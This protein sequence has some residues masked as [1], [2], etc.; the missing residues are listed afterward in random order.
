MSRPAAVHPA[1]P[2]VSQGITGLLCAE[3]LAFRTWPPVVVALVLILLALAGPRWSPVAWGFRLIARPPD[4]LEPAAPVRF[5]QGIAAVL[6]TAA[7]ALWIAGL[8]TAGWALVGLVAAVALFSAVSGVC[9]GCHAWRLLLARRTT[10]EDLRGPL[11]LTGDG[12]WLVLVTAPGCA[13]CEPAARELAHLAEGREVVRVDLA[14]RPQAGGLPIQS[15]PA[16]LAVGRDGRLLEARS[17]RLAAED[18]RAVVAAA[19]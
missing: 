16:V 10:G 8:E 5:A 6:L 1:L 19:A 12:P 7:V 13:R 9:I 15:V 18:H 17:G 3:S 4:R 2:R 11:G 14:R